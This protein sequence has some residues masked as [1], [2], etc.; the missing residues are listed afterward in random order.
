G[1]ARSRRASRLHRVPID[2]RKRADYREDGIQ[3]GVVG[4]WARVGLPH[5]GRRVSLQDGAADRGEP[6]GGGTRCADGDGLQG[7]RGGREG[8]P[9]GAR[10]GISWPPS[11]EGPLPSQSISLK[12]G[13][14][15][16]VLLNG[17][18]TKLRAVFHIKFPPK[19]PCAR[20]RADGEHR[21]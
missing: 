2:G 13:A 5:R 20:L 10:H 15:R 3:G 21:I 6:G 9:V 4:A 1:H 12:N 14:Y 8:V 19:R 18:P 17:I 16:F 7:T 11:L